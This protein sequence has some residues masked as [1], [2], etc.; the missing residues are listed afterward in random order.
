MTHDNDWAALT[1]ELI[2]EGYTPSEAGE[3]ARRQLG[4]LN[5]YCTEWDQGAQASRPRLTAMVLLALLLGGL[6]LITLL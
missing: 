4:E 2:N 5:G 3:L 6:V 1:M